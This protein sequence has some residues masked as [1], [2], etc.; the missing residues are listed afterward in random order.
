MSTLFVPSPNCQSNI[1]TQKI[2][3]PRTRPD[4]DISPVERRNQYKYLLHRQRHAKLDRMQASAVIWGNG[5]DVSQA[6]AFNFDQFATRRPVFGCDVHSELESMEISG[7]I[8]LNKSFDCDKLREDL[9][10]RYENDL[11][12]YEVYV[13]SDARGERIQ[14]RLDS[15]GPAGELSM[16]VKVNQR[17]DDAE[18][19]RAVTERIDVM[20]DELDSS[21]QTL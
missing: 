7:F 17:M 13:L 10:Q 3:P 6:N 21:L 19:M 15:R 4:F 2:T 16:D 14:V 8:N 18:L 12:P 5:A 20:L 11:R 1:K 9:V